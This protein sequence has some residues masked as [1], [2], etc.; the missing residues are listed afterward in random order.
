MAEGSR[1]RQ[2][3]SE[4]RK[5]RVRAKIYGTPEQPRLSVFRSLKQMYAQLVDDLNQKTLAS[6]STL[7][8][9]VREQVSGGKK[10]KGDRAKL[11]G[12]ALADLA[13]TKG[14]EK[15]VFDR[16]RYRYHGRVKALADGARE[17]GLKF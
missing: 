16:N 10:T 17:G 9:S 1:T 4:R 6:L 2:K 3:K 11:L 12:K 5:K 7:S 13:R 8:A 14:I 15:V